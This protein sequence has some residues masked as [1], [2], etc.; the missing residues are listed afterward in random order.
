VKSIQKFNLLPNHLILKYYKLG[1]CKIG[2]HKIAGHHGYAHV[3]PN[4]KFLIGTGGNELNHCDH[5][6]S[7]DFIAC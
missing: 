1:Y 3:F 7:P 4:F 5:T 2:L 6:Y